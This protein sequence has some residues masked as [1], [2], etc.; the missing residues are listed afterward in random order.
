MSDAAYVDRN[1]QV[2]VLTEPCGLRLVGQVDLSHRAVLERELNR[3]VN[4]GGA[5]LYL[6]ISSLD[7]IDV[8]GMRLILDTAGV[9]ALDSRKLVLGHP[10]HGVLRV[11]RICNWESAQNIEILDGRG[12]D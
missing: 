4:G 2:H 5:D 7:F 12:T 1:F 8:G 9:L 6:D 11:L 3:A 10:Q